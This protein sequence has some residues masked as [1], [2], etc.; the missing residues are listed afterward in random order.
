MRKE[1]TKHFAVVSKK[2]GVKNM[3]NKKVIV[4]TKG[5]NVSLASVNGRLMTIPNTVF[6]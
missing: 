6:E 2:H 5:D 3:K 1:V 4:I